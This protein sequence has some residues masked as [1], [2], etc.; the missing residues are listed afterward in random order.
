MTLKVLIPAKT[1]LELEGKTL[2]LVPPRRCSRC[3]AP[4]APFFET[5][6]LRYRADLIPN[7]NVAHR[8]RINK[9][10]RLRLP[11]CAQCYRASFGEDPESFIFDA[12]P[13]GRIARFRSAAIKVAAIIALAGFVLLMG[14]FPLPEVV[15]AI[16]FFWLYIILVAV[17]LLALVFALTAWVSRSLQKKTGISDYNQKYR[18]TVAYEAIETD[19]PSPK[20][21]AVFLHL[22]NEAW[23]KECADLHHWKYESPDSPSEKENE[24]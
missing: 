8:Y 12:T 21:T 2:D 18:R 3:D 13:L 7:R 14:L 10:L 1:I 17:G 5:H 4:D 6:S 24:K 20:K 23:A 9:S 11:L 19:K 16:P 15:T 22:A